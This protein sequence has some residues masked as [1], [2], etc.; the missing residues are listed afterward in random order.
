MRELGV[1]RGRSWSS[2]ID[3]SG[4]AAVDDGDGAVERAG[5]DERKELK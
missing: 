4:G 2:F 3:A 5:E 1:C